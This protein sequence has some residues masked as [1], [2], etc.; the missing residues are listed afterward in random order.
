M[1]EFKE[2][3]FSSIYDIKRKNGK[4]AI[5]LVEYKD[6]KNKKKEYAIKTIC[7]S[8]NQTDK[9]KEIV[10][11]EEE[12]AKNQLLMHVNTVKYY[13]HYTSKSMKIT[14]VLPEKEQNVHEGEEIGEE[15]EDGEDKKR[16]ENGKEKSKLLNGEEVDMNIEDEDDKKI[17]EIDEKDK[18]QEKDEVE[19]NFI[20]DD[21]YKLILE[22]REFYN[23][24]MEYSFIGSLKEERIKRIIAEEPFNEEEILNYLY[25]ICKGVN[26]I[27]SKNMCHGN[28]KLSNVLIFNKTLKITDFSNCK[29]FDM[30][31]NKNEAQKKFNEDIKMIGKMLYELLMTRKNASNM[32]Y[33]KLRKD[34]QHSNC[35]SELKSIALLL[36]DEKYHTINEVLSAF[37]NNELKG[38]P[39]SN[40]IKFDFN[41]G[42]CELLN[43]IGI[44]SI[45]FKNGHSAFKTL[46]LS[47]IIDLVPYSLIEGQKS[48]FN[49]IIIDG[50]YSLHRKY[51][52][53][54]CICLRCSCFMKCDPYCPGKNSFNI[55]KAFKSYKSLISH[56]RKNK[57]SIKYCILNVKLNPKTWT[58]FKSKKNAN[59]FFI[60]RIGAIDSK[61]YDKYDKTNSKL[62][63]K[64]EEVKNPY[65]TK[66]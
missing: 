41:F 21:Q 45:F 65:Y 7:L 54:Y 28:L 49:N 47:D 25:Q 53:N 5:K 58:L 40:D 22:P 64:H 1:E 34:I 46:V 52:E 51:E 14:M 23:I 57:H 59:Y 18:I 62:M 44:N 20:D 38:I 60:N 42:K 10:K 66:K 36:F 16:K 35:S 31:K 6:N 30:K 19:E 4:I 55:L 39:F 61:I 33:E 11:A 24:V 3:Q 8:S 15:C 56:N 12:C 9:E 2:G 37:N 27:H 29:V 43:D 63:K 13:G 48:F 26:E 50:D 32:K 17:K